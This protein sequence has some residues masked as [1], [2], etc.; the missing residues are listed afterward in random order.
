MLRRALLYDKVKVIKE[1]NVRHLNCKRKDE[2]F[3]LFEVRMILRDV[4]F[5]VKVLSSDPMPLFFSV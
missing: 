1:R 4:H 5:N 2:S 3:G